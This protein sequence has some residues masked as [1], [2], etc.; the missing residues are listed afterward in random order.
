MDNDELNRQIMARLATQKEQ[1]RR[2][3]EDT[4]NTDFDNFINEGSKDPT[5]SKLIRELSSNPKFSQTLFDTNSPE[6]VYETLNEEP[7]SPIYANKF[8]QLK[9]LIQKKNLYDVGRRLSERPDFSERVRS[10]MEYADQMD[11]GL[12]DPNDVLQD[13]FSQTR[14]RI[15]K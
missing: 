13:K 8:N 10:G 4:S 7:E 15:G 11:Q 3:N 6:R 9:E 1:N 5:L 2:R 12:P 14:K